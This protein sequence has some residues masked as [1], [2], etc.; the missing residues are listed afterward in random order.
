MIVLALILKCTYI[1]KVWRNPMSGY[2]IGSSVDIGSIVRCLLIKTKKKKKKSTC[3]LLFKNIWY[4]YTHFGQKGAGRSA[5]L[6]VL[7]I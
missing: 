1:N 3:Y 6:L 2:D 5:E 7:Q 4:L